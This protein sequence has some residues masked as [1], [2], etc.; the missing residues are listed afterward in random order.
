MGLGVLVAVGV[1]LG[2]AVGVRVG[3]SVVVDVGESV[4][5][6]VAVV[7]AVGSSVVVGRDVGVNVAVAV[8]VSVGGI[9]VMVVVVGVASGVE[10]GGWGSGESARMTGRKPVVLKSSAPADRDQ[11]RTPNQPTAMTI[12]KPIHTRFDMLS[13]LLW[14]SAG[15]G[16]GRRVGRARARCGIS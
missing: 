1:L 11:L 6:V 4:A 12:A 9:R 14:F 5:V 8:W 16:L 10:V 7:V 15:A 2:V 13:S 3:V